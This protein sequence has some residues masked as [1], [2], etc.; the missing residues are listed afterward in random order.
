MHIQVISLFPKLF[1]ALT[2]EGVIA[3]ALEKGLWRLNLLNPRDFADNDLGYVDDR[4][5]GGG[6]GMVLQAEPVWL[7]YQAAIQKAQSAPRL[8]YLSPQGSSLNEAKILVLA[9]EKELILLCGRYEGVDERFL[10]KSGAEEV[11]IGDF[12]VSGGELPAMMLIDA[13]LRKQP[14]VL[15]DSRSAEED[16]FAV[17]LLDY[18]HYTRPSVW[19]GLKTPE[20]LLSGDH[21]KIALWRKQNALTRTLTRRPD[22]LAGQSLNQE[23]ACLLH[24][25]Q[26]RQ[27][28]PIK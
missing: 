17:G 19:R 2:Q 28:K 1:E 20:V 3:R 5:F 6:P 21:K 18:A 24:A 10:Q 4:P 26:E 9:K 22:L 13:L 15:G 16:S 25:L 8:L 7:A 27:A 23:D 11:S 12:V 14:G